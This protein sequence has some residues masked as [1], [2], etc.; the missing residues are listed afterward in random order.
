MCMAQQTDDMNTFIAYFFSPKITY[1]GSAL[2]LATCAFLTNPSFCR[3]VTKIY[4]TQPRLVS[5]QLPV[6]FS[7]QF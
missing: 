5:S 2:A 4:T 7:A 6:D 1:S 3:T